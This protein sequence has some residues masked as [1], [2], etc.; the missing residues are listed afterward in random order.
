MAD[1]VTSES[2]RSYASI[3]FAVEACACQT[4]EREQSV[5]NLR[6]VL[7]EKRNFV[8]HT[9][10]RCN[11][12]FLS[13]AVSWELSVSR[14]LSRSKSL[15]K[16]MAKRAVLR[17]DAYLWIIV[18]VQ[19]WEEHKVF[20]ILLA[21]KQCAST[22]ITNLLVDFVHIMKKIA[23]VSGIREFLCTLLVYNASKCGKLS[24]LRWVAST[25]KVRR[26]LTAAAEYSDWLYKGSN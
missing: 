2:L 1:A 5:T 26:V 20:R 10:E 12:I 13:L 7:W 6:K 9:S 14:D 24:W 16:C 8:W 22:P 19:F 25:L 15:K 3:N 17:S 23:P 21:C 4:V 18:N 11:K